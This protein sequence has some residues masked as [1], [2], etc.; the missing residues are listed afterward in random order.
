MAVKVT[1]VLEQI[2]LAD[3]AM[4]TVGVTGVLA[5][6]VIPLLVTVGTAKQV[7]LDVST[8]VTTSL[9]FNVVEVNVLLFVPTFV[10]FT[11]H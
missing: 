3:A 9:L 2:L 5:I 6:I 8:Q 7:A 1:L 11:C 10:P 4:L